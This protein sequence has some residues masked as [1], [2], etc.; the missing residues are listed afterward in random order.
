MTILDLKANW[1]QVKGG[2]RQRYAI[3]TDDDLNFAEGKGEELFGRL[4]EKL[5]IGEEELQHILQELNAKAG[6]LRGKVEDVKAK[7][8][9]VFDEVKHKASG[10]VDD[11]RAA[12]SL[13]AEEVVAEAK[14]RARTLHEDAEEYVRQ[15][16][17]QALFTALAAGFVA[18][19][20][21]RR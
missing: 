6:G 12:A 11:A 8:S 16:P 2:L 13:K 4:Q 7:A 21:L 19:L 18:G 10:Y 15:Q 3:L 5:G 20:L 1:K 14:Q 17:R 9:E